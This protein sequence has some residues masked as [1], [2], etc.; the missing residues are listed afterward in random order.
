M[1]AVDH[2]VARDLCIGLDAAAP[3]SDAGIHGGVED[4]VE[5]PGERGEITLGDVQRDRADAGALELVPLSGVSESG[6]PPDL[7]VLRQL[8]GDGKGDL[9]AR[10]R[11]EHLLAFEHAGLHPL[12]AEINS[13]I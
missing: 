9:P 5:V 12:A 13:L 6:D 10:S 8:P 4:V 2:E 3:I 11:D 1:A 7:V